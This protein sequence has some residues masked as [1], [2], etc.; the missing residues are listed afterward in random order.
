MNNQQYPTCARCGHPMEIHTGQY[1][2]A[3]ETGYALRF[4]QPNACAWW[5]FDERRHCPCEQYIV[6]EEWPRPGK[7][8]AMLLKVTPEF[9]V[10]L[11]RGKYEIT[12]NPVPLDAA[13]RAC[14][15]D[16]DRHCFVITLEH[17]T[18]EETTEGLPLPI[19]SSPTI[20]RLDE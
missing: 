6:P 10:R 5:I 18:F 4:D 7:R 17:S 15:Y 19:L 1:V 8:A 14:G 16:Q 12:G 3:T 13:I 9:I 20:H 2:K 11:C